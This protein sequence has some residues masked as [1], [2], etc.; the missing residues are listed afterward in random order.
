[1]KPEGL[2]YH[3]EGKESLDSYMEFNSYIKCKSIT[4]YGELLLIFK[5]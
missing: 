5:T 4:C 3:L 2:W 1:M